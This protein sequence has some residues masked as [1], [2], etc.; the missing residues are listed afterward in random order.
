MNLYHLQKTE[1]EENDAVKRD[2][3]LMYLLGMKVMS[4][5]LEMKKPDINKI[6]I[7]MKH[8]TES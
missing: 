3:L 1:G 7:E 8:D 5:H 2:V 6:E 4:D